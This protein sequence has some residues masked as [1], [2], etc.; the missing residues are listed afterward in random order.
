MRSI[1]IAA[2]ATA[3][4]ALTTAC[5]TGPPPAPPPPAPSVGVGFQP[6]R[7]WA[8][9]EALTSIGPRASG[10]EGAERGRTYIREQLSELGLDVEEQRTTLE[11]EEIEPIEIVNLIATIPGAS[12]ELFVLVAP[13]DTAYF[14]S[15]SF[16]GA[17]EGGSGAALL[18]ELARVLVEQPLAYTVVL[19]FLDGEAP[20][21][22]GGPGIET[23]R[24]HGSTALAERYE[25]DGQIPDIRLLVAFNRI[26]DADLRIARD[27]AS[28]RIY[29]EEFWA[30]AS[31]LGHEDA[32]SPTD[33]FS[34]P[35]ESHLAF[36]ARGVRSLVVI[37]DTSF[38]GDDPPGLY[39]RTEDDVLAHCAT[40]SLA[41][42]GAVTLQTL[43]TLSARLAKIDRFAR[44]P[45]APIAE[46][47]PEPPF[48]QSAPPEP[49][50]AESDDAP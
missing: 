48:E 41:S 39:A 43:E 7:A 40:E 42:V 31:R 46:E 13:Y 14:D 9:L 36:R 35:E 30:V 20:L 27:L 34:S 26:C 45:L 37:A 22:R 17:N 8:H 33:S 16:V 4:L 25:E 47:E 12:P 3:W 21:G 24:F 6:E 10:T 28:H 49:D 38:G 5:E 19:A 29:R 15:F 23:R 44:S 11:L 18:L 32:F 1:A 50:P 2:V